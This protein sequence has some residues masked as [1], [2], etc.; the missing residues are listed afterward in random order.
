MILI[1]SVNGSLLYNPNAGECNRIDFFRYLVCNAAGCD[2]ALVAIYL[3]C[4]TEVKPF[5][6]YDAFSPN[7]DNVNEVFRID[8]LELYPNHL[9][10]VLN[11][12]GQEVLR[13]KNYQ[14]DWSGDWNSKQLPDGTYFYV[15]DTGEGNVLK[16]FVEIRR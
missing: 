2:T 3:K 14:N 11:R 9:V 6:I 10:C 12:W 5:K 16:G 13:T 8:G 4:K 1:D 7:G 15:F